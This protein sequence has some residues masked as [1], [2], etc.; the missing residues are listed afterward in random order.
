[1]PAADVVG[2]DVLLA[3]TDPIRKRVT[4]LAHTGR[5]VLLLARTG[6]PLVDQDVPADIRPAALVTLT[7]QVRPDAAEIGRASCRERV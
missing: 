3:D 1:M 7:E 6:A 4:E 5:R 2:Y